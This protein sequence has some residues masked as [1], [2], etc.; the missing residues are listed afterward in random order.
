MIIVFISPGWDRPSGIWGQKPEGTVHSWRG[1]GCPY[2]EI[3]H[4]RLLLWS[5]QLCLSLT[6][7]ANTVCHCREWVNPRYGPV[8]GEEMVS[9]APAK[10]DQT[11]QKHQLSCFWQTKL[12]PQKVCWLWCLW[13]NAQKMDYV[14]DYLIK[15]KYKVGNCLSNN[16]FC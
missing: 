11:K 12:Y 6:S 8:Q 9:V 7:E 13:L 10:M 15:E 2:Q 4:S 3:Y 1:L 5:L 16:L 14:M